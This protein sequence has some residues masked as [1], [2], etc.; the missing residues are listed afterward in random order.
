MKLARIIGK[1]LSE[2]PMAPDIKRP[3][4]HTSVGIEVEVENVFRFQNIEWK[5]WS[6]VT[7]GSI[8]DGIE[9]VS[10]PVWG[11]AITD[12]L[13]ELGDYLETQEP[14]ISFR[15]S[16][17][18]HMNVLDISKEQL[19][20][21][22]ELYLAYEPTLFRLHQEYDRANCVFCIPAYNSHV[23]TKGYG[24]LLKDLKH[25]QVRGAYIPCKYSAMN[26]NC[27]S[28]L[29]T[30][31]FRQMGGTTDMNKISDWI[32]ILLQLKVA[33]IKGVDYKKPSEVWGSYEK[34]LDIK[35]D[36]LSLGKRSLS[37]LNLW[38]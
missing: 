8:L 4:P 29:G 22:I 38:R 5:R 34:L 12:A 30:L 21:L 17:H 2:I 14:N 13:D 35:E 10:E 15:T 32:N 37:F 20:N 18:I 31:E 26:I 24:Q 7:E 6:T 36:D 19:S 25:D 9:F 1:K 33:A 23:I 3:H 28:S 11:T 27:L 16:V